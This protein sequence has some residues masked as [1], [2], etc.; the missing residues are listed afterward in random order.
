MSPEERIRKH[1]RRYKEIIERWNTASGRG[2][3]KW[4]EPAG[5]RRSNS[6]AEERATGIENAREQTGSEK[7][8]RSR[9]DKTDEEIR[10]I[11]YQAETETGETNECGVGGPEPGVAVRGAG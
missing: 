7:P 1:V 9:R 11:R 2:G 5:R 8:D 10:E 4:E 3:K 6:R